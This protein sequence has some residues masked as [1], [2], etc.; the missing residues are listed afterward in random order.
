MRRD[1]QMVFQDPMAAL[2]PRMPVVRHD[3]RAAAAL[4]EAA[5]RRWPSGSSELLRAGR[6]RTGARQPLP[7]GVLRRPAP[8][9]RHRPGA[10]ARAQADRAGRAGVRAGRVDP[11]RRDQPAGRAQGP[12]RAVV[13]VRGPRPRR[14][15][16]HR[17]PGG[18]DVPRADRGD[19]RRSTRCSTSRA[20]R[21][22]RRCCRRS[23]CPTRR[24]SARRARVLLRGDLPSPTDPSPGCRFVSRCPLHLTLD[25]TG[26]DRCRRETPAL[27][28]A[29]T[30]DHRLRHRVDH[31]TA[32][33][34]R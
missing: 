17:R 7:A 18:G 1:L 30:V 20:T 24:Q 8:A 23:R 28:G 31:R 11:G 19:R 6:A 9:H 12:A 16:P 21:T 32:C 33:R 5:K 2:D 34:F 14:G 15:P 25:E 3:R 4:T 10:G 22:P 26:R 27:T 29:G 13:P